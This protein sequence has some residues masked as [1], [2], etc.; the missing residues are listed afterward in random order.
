MELGTFISKKMND[1]SAAANSALS[2]GDF[3][4]DV[5]GRAYLLMGHIWANAKVTGEKCPG[6]RQTC[7]FLVAVD[8]FVKQ[9]RQILH[10]KKNATVLLP[11]TGSISFTGRGLHAR[12]G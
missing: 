12:S 11:L 10:W 2:A 4:E 3:N 5:I 7:Q 9:N 6:N 1:A 8:Y